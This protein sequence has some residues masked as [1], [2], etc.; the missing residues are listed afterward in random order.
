M[1]YLNLDQTH[2]SRTSLG[3]KRNYR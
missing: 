2:P 3:Q 1:I